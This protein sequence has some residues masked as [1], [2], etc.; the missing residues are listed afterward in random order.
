MSETW[1]VTERKLVWDR[2]T[3]TW[4]QQERV[5]AAGVSRA[6]ADAL[7]MSGRHHDWCAAPDVA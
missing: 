5:I 4:S 1:T 7:L 2:A 6:R 3:R